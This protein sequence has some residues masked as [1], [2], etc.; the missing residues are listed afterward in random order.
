[1]KINRT[2]LAAIA[3]AAM[4][5]TDAKAVWVRTPPP[6]PRST[7]V[8]GR[9]PGPGFVWTPGFYR[10]SGRNYVWVGGRWRRPPRRGA[11][12]MPPVWRPGPGG[13]TFVAGRWR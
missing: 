11:V 2:L 7:A 9:P 6:P 13:W 8:I 1:M 4:L 10:W 12:W 5:A 3:M